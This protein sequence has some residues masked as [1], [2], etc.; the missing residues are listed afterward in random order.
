[1]IL[2]RAK[3][4]IRRRITTI[5]IV[6]FIVSL[7]A[8]NTFVYADYDTDCSQD[9]LFCIVKTRLN[10]FFFQEESDPRLDQVNW[11]FFIKSIKTGVTQNSES[12][13]KQV[14]V[15]DSQIPADIIP[16]ELTPELQEPETPVTILPPPVVKPQITRPVIQQKI[17]PQINQSFKT[18]PFLLARILI[19]ENNLAKSIAFNKGQAIRTQDSSS[20]NTS[21]ASENITQNGKLS[22][23]T[24]NG[25]SAITGKAIF[26][27]IPTLAHV[28]TAW[29]T[30]TSNADDASLYVNPSSADGN[31]NLIAAAVADDVKFVVDAEGDIYANN[32]I[33]K[34]A[35]SSGTTTLPFILGGT[36]TTQDLTLQTTSGVGATG[37]DIHFLTGNNGSTE[38]LTIL[39][40]GKVGIGTIAPSQALDITGNIALSGTVDGR[41]I[42]ADG[43]KLDGIEAGVIN[44][45]T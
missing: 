19:L 8:P 30:G 22:G 10:S 32:L 18:D 15:L 1:M 31:T 12:N 11:K 7:F 21:N 24:L 26:S 39:N 41:D 38:A 34:G 17:F 2:F 3:L 36:T 29:P 35:L 43:I 5:F 33:L 28:Y 14:P 16:T 9:K 45:A 13:P 4:S 37:A 27:H 44:T 23:V 6:I 20:N 25:T 40:D 42:S